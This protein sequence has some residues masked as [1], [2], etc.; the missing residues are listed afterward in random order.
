LRIGLQI[1]KEFI[2]L[3]LFDSTFYFKLIDDT[4]PDVLR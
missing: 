3:Q 1:Y 4:C 2:V